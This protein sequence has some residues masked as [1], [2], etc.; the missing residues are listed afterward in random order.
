MFNRDDYVI[1][2]TKYESIRR[3]AENDVE[4]HRERLC[5]EI[6]ELK[7]IC[8]MLSDTG[9]RVYAA[10]LEGGENYAA[11]LEQI[12]RENEELLKKQRDILTQN[13]YPADYLDIKYNCPLCRD[14]GNIDGKMCE[15][16]RKELVFAGYESAG[17]AGLCGKMNFDTFDLSYYDGAERRNMEVILQRVRE[18]AESFSDAGSGSVLFFGGT[19]LGKTHLS[20]AVAKRVIEGGHNCVYTT[21]DKLFSDFRKYRFDREDDGRKTDKYYDCELLVID[22]LGTELNGKDI[23]S[24]LYNLLNQRINNEKSTLISTNLSHQELLAKY[25]DRIVSRLFGEFLPYRFT[26]KDVRMQKLQK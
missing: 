9:P 8:D 14:E 17:I 19:G 26:G 13:G 3:K 23:E 1:I 15:C 4:E 20:V 21:S 16:M 24:F 6:P 10:A 25:D 7:K 5:K 18:Y 11:R 12:K 22:D 2:K